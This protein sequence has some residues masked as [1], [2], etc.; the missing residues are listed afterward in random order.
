MIAYIKL[1]FTILFL[2]ENLAM[3]KK[4]II[5]ITLASIFLIVQARNDLV[6]GQVVPGQVLLYSVRVLKKFNE[7]NNIKLK[8][9]AIS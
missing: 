1:H 6:V 4:V 7:Q 8:F 5:I 3:E 9:K 2:S